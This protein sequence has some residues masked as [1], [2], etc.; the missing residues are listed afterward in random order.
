MGILIAAICVIGIGLTVVWFSPL[1]P[2]LLQSC[3]RFS[4]FKFSCRVERLKDDTLPAA[5]SESFCVQMIGC[6][7]TP[8]DNFDTDIR[9]EIEDVTAGL[10]RSEPVLTVD[11]QYRRDEEAAVY[12]Q[13]HN[14][15]VPEKNAV[16]SHWVTIVTIPCHV[17]RFAYRGRR[18][19]LCKLSV[20]SSETGQVLAT[21]QQT[22]EYVYCAEGYRQIQDRKLEIL[23]ASMQLALAVVQEDSP[24]DQIRPFL[25]QWLHQIAQSFTAAGQLKTSID[26]LDEQG[27]LLTLEQMAEPLL[28]FGE[29]PDRVAALQLILQSLAID[30][31]ITGSKSQALCRVAGILEMKS[32]RFRVL[33][34]KHLLTDEC[35]I[36]DPGFLLG[37][38]SSMDQHTFRARLNEEYRKW[39]SRVTHPKKDIRRQA[40]QMLTLIADL[41][42][43]QISQVCL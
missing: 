24:R 18:K 29:L 32:D 38:D 37:V 14:G 1:R 30:K 31:K 22:I 41:R 3:A 33:C 6:I 11:P 7:P 36:E 26:S 43:R 28:A 4:R 12:V 25:A 39:N 21:D 13:T 15:C 8:C 40:D 17:L 9:L 2:V 34:Q 10:F 35:E 23:K 42:T 5:E 27:R 16:L 20:L 19:L